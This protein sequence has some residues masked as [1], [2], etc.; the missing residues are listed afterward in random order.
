MP[1]P[2]HQQSTRALQELIETIERRVVDAMIPNDGRAGRSVSR[3]V[4]LTDPEV[5]SAIREAKAVLGCKT[6]L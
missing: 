3:V 1:I 6:F 5:M 4:S 2:Q